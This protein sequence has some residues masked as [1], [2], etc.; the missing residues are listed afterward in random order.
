MFCERCK[1]EHDGSYASGRF[2]SAKCARGFSTANNREETSRKVSQTIKRKIS[3][4]EIQLEQLREYQ[5]LAAK[6]AKQHFEKL[7]HSKSFNEFSFE[8]QRR[9]VIEEQQ[10][11]CADCGLAEWQGFSLVLEIDH[12][13]GNNQNNQRSNLRGLCPN[14]HSLTSTWRGRNKAKKTC[15]DDEIIEAILSHKTIHATLKAVGL[16]P[17]GK[18]YERCKR[19]LT[20]IERNTE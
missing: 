2:C 11:Q 15:T 13:D 5:E 17:K 8:T 14:C 7:R 12:Y 3:E 16:A 9:I 6:A 18:N 10:G 4:G 1:N 20:I 19:L